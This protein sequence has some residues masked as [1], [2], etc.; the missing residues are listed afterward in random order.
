M[1]HVFKPFW[2]RIRGHQSNFIFFVNDVTRG[3]Y[4]CHNGS[5]FMYIWMMSSFPES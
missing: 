3:V 4:L 1:G 5:I 2:L